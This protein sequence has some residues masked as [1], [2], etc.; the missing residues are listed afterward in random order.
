MLKKTTGNLVCLLAFILSAKSL[1]AQSNNDS[2]FNQLNIVLAKKEYYVQLKEERIKK[3][4][5]QLHSNTTLT[6]QFAIYQALYNEYKSFRYDSAYSYSKKLLRTAQMLNDPVKVA[7]SKMNIGFTLLSAGMFK[8]T[9]EKLDQLDVS[10]LDHA[11]RIDYYFLKGRCYLDWGDFDH[12]NDYN[13]VYY[14]KAI[15]FIDSALS[16][17]IPRSSNYWAL[18]GLK[19]MRI[20][21]YKESERDYLSLL[22]LPHITPGQF[23]ISASSLS[24]VYNVQGKHAQAISLLIAAAE[25]DIQ[26]ATKETVAIYELANILYKNGNKNDAFNYI[27]EAM[28]EA[29]FYG[30]RQRQVTISSI[31]PIIEA[32]RV[33]TVEQ[34]RRSLLIYAS[35]ITLLV[36]FVIAFTFIVFRQLKKLRI[37]DNIIKDANASLQKSNNIL[38]ELNKKLGIANKIKNEYIGYYFNIN[39]IYIDK[40]ENFKKSL[41]KKLISK[42]YE[43]ALVAVNNLNLDAERKELYYTFDKVFLRLFPDFIEKYN[44]LFDPK[45][46]A[47][48][49]K[50]ELLNTE[51]RIFALIRMGLHET[52]RISRILGYSVNTIYAYKNRIKTK[53]LIINEDF[54]YHIMAIDAI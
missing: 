7:L 47:I 40:L 4:Q 27:K 45:D 37:A 25:T 33:A 44:S 10:L 41:N 11:T 49:P 32:Q 48:I 46:Q 36:F 26:S 6:K 52:E 22:K 38:E 18:L 23:A 17:S 9:L 1:H 3:Y 50:E 24:Y 30:A 2:L 29:T 15:T 5:T 21:R 53:S 28:D 20:R 35:I 16:L 31:L 19:N 42:R 8:E 51:L 13:D 34:D 14:P 54:E 39:S 43:D 12:N